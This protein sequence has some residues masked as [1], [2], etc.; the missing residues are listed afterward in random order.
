MKAFQLIE[1][2]TAILHDIAVPEPGPG[3]VLVRVAG[4]GVCH[5]DLHLLHMKRWKPLP[6]TLG[7][8]VAGH[9]AAL[10]P[11]VDSWTTGTPVLGYL[12]WGCGRCRTCAAGFENYCEAAGRGITPGP[13]LGFPGSMAEYVVFP[14]RHLVALGDQLDPVEAAP[15]TDAGL[16]PWHAVNQVREQLGGAGT[17]VVIGVGG[18][19]HMAVQ[20]LAATTAAEIIAVDTDP[21]RLEHARDLGASTTLVSDATTAEALLEHTRGRGAEAVL[22]FVGAGATLDLAAATV[23][24]FGRIAV[25][26]LAGGTL[27]FLA[28]G[29]PHGLPWGAS[30]IKPYGGTRAELHDLV[31]AAARG[32]ISATVERHA[33]DDAAEVF[34]RLDEGRVS[35][36]A[37]LVP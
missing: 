2:G 23:A 7:H 26:G 3:E 4:A 27:P 1:P 36:R 5:S 18:L 19:G 12:C 17:A 10:G 8:E 35:G 33:L 6:M 34:T 37:V 22:D 15:L 20:V 29:P 24:P 32:T 9:V 28:G 25:V 16:T 14:A 31:R 13:G 21:A 30:V 11:G